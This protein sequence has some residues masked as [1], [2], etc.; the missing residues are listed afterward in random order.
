MSSQPRATVH[1]T[2][3]VANW[4]TIGA[5]APQSETG[6]VV[7]AN[8]YGHGAGPVAKALQAAG[9][10]TFFVAY[11]EEGAELRSILGDEATILAFNG[12][13]ADDAENVRTSAVLPVM[14]SIPALR[15]WLSR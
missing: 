13:E 3:I 5:L 4:R 15:N 2:H 8:A 11:I 1:L 12:A 14:N 7:K 6:A 10:R 9:C